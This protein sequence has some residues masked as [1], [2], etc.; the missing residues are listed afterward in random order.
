[1]K[2]RRYSDGEHDR[3][4]RL[5]HEN[6]KLKKQISALRKQ[7]SRID[8]DRFQ[9]LKDLLDAQDREN[10]Q[11]ALARRQEDAQ[12]EWQ[13]W[14]CSEGTLRLTILERRDGVFYYRKCDS[15]PKR[16]RLQPY[17]AKVKEGPR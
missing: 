2:R 9:N 13:C 12:K 14:D 17:G 4:Q 6:Q 3:M 8:V 7:M 16:T 5:V 10:Q 11:E 1:M 15:C